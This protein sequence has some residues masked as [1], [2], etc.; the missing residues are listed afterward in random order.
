MK[1]LMIGTFFAI[2]GAFQLLGALI[3]I[4]PFL[5]WNST[6]SFPSCGFVYYVVNMVV[7]FFG[8]IIFIWVAKRYQNQERDEP[9]NI[10]QYAEEYY[11]KVQDQRKYD[12]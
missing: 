3:F 12:Y 7:A 11:E 6:S 2:R 1:S 5:A 10:Y 4:F 8:M 9:D